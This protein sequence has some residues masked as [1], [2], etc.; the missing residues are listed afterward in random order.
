MADDIFSAQPDSI[1]PDDTDKTLSDITLPMR[2]SALSESITIP[3]SQHAAVWPPPYPMYRRRETFSSAQLI[4]IISLVGLLI[5]SG[6]G[7]VIYAATVQYHSSLKAQA[8]RQAQA[9]ALVH[10]TVTA[11]A[12]ATNQ[13]LATAQAHID[14]TAT[15]QANAA[16]TATAQ[17]N[18]A[19]ATATSFQDMLSTVTSGTAALDDPLSDNS[20]HNGWD[21][22]A[23]KTGNCMFTND[24]YQASEALQ[25]Y[26]QPCI[27]EA[28]NFSNFVYQVQLSITQ[29]NQ[30]GILFRAD[31]A[32]GTFYLFRIGTDG[33]YALDLYNGKQ[34]SKTLASGFSDAISTGINQAN[35]MAVYAKGSTLYLFINGQYVTGLSDSTLS[36]GEIGVVALDYSVPSL[37]TF[38]DAQVW[39]V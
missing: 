1:S 30:G 22:G 33:S 17:V 34:H 38:S 6:L 27:A 2:F 16:A 21:E 25:G 18:Q 5:L 19:T 39:K 28:T 13:V 4:L 7:L 36:S 15:A 35:Q 23:T 3:D 24:E 26:L 32:N 20:Q 12:Q 9:T 10:A 14:A 29:G 8:T 31:G 11:Q 37:V